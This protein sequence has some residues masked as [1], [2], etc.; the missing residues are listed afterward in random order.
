MKDS[1]VFVAPNSHINALAQ[2]VVSQLN[3]NIPVIEA[4]DYNAIEALR[5]YPS[6]HIVISRGGTANYLKG[7]KG[8]TVIDLT[9]S[10]FD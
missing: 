10:F 4:Y 2:S 8:L 6:C 9:A 3:L 7:I 1:I 5:K